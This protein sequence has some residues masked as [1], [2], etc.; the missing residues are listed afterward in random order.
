MDKRLYIIGGAEDKEGDCTILRNFVETVSEFGS[1]IVVLTTA[2]E[3]P[4]KVGKMYRKVLKNLSDK[5]RVD[6]VDVSE[7]KDSFKQKSLELL[8]QASGIFVTGGNQLHTT[9]YMGGSPMEK[10][11]RSAI[12]R[13]AIIA[14]TSAGAAMM[15]ELMYIA[16]VAEDSPRLANIRF[17]SGFRFLP[18]TIIDTHYSQRG[19]ITRLFTAICQ[20][21][22][23]LG[24]AI[25]EDTALIVNG[26]VGEVIGS[27]TVTFM[28]GRNMKH[29]TI[30]ISSFTESFTATNLTINVLDQGQRFNLKKREVLY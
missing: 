11:I 4:K 15:S 12:K 5:I 1:S 13:G 10:E 19:R 7:R 22:K 23:L 20:N 24:I 27:G 8:S 17:G 16:G 14:G 21:P 18:N 9:A 28:D 6:V 2:T 30:S 3:K 29:N 25:D 26:N